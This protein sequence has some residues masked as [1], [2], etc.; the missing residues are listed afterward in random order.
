MSGEE[1][2]MSAPVM[3]EATRIAIE[4]AERQR[5]QRMLD[6]EDLQFSMPVTINP[7]IYIGRSKLQQAAQSWLEDWV[8]KT[9]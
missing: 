5:I 1:I 7:E 6:A 2:V 4:V 9:C 3:I 8:M